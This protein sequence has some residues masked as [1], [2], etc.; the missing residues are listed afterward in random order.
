MSADRDTYFT[1]GD[2]ICDPSVETF[3]FH[4]QQE[5]ESVLLSVVD[6]PLIDKAM[7]VATITAQS[8][9]KLQQQDPDSPAVVL[10]DLKSL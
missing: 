1:V 3:S 4:L 2:T 5:F 6:V 9:R 8:V 7:Q 10:V